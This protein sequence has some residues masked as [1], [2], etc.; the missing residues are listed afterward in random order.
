MR[1]A[2][3]LTLLLGVCALAG[4]TH[5]NWWCR[6]FWPGQNWPHCVGESCCDDY[7]PKPLPCPRS[8]GC[9]ECPDYCPKGPPCPRCMCD[10]TCDDYCPKPVPKVRCPGV[11]LE[12]WPW[13]SCSST[14]P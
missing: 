14:N 4:T 2:F 8:A 3:W 1:I 11:N 5:G 6:L 9:F 12:C 10:F 7:C 13:R